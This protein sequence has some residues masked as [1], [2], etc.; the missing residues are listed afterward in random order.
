MINFGKHSVLGVN[1]CAVDYECAVQSIIK[2]AIQGSPYGVSALAVHGVMTGVMDAQHRNRLNTLSMVVPDGQPVRYALRILYRISLPDRVYGPKLTILVLEA[3]VKNNIPIYLYGSQPK[4]INQMVNKLTSLYPGINI[5]GYRPSLFRAMTN[6]DVIEVVDEIN[7][8]GARMVL[9]GLGCPRQEMWAS[10]FQSEI[11]MPILAVG[12]AF[13]F[14][15]GSLEQAPPILQRFSLEWLYRLWK[16]PNRLWRRYIILNPIYIYYIMCQ[17][18][19]W[20][21]RCVIRPERSLT[22]PLPG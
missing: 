21:V 6:Y 11:S 15:A 2:A 7:K 19:T 9:C 1:I 12:A 4:V 22:G 10:R 16:E 14:I 3:A 17:L 20:K 13:D 18:F 8:S 5:A